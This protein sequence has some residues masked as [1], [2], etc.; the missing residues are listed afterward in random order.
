MKHKIH[1]HYNLRIVVLSIT[2]M[3]LIAAGL[4][5]TTSA[6]PVHAQVSED[7]DY[8]GAKECQSCHR[9]IASTHKDTRHSLTL[10]DAKPA[11]ILGNFD[12]DDSIRQVQFPGEDAPRAFTAD[13]IAFT[14]GSGRNVQRYLY[15]VESNEYRLEQNRWER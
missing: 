11:A 4:F 2:G 1:Y 9:G 12:Q 14:I 3:L 15:K 13:D 5:M 8:I 10:Q 7:A 6:V